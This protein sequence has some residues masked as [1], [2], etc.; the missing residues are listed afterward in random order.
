MENLAIELKNGPCMADEQE[1]TQRFKEGSF[2]TMRDKIEQF[3]SDDYAQVTA[4]V[5]LAT[6]EPSLADDG[7]QGALLKVASHDKQYDAFAARVMVVAA[8]D[9]RL[10]ARRQA[11]ADRDAGIEKVSAQPSPTSLGDTVLHQAL[12]EL[13]QRQREVALLHYYLDAS[14]D[15]IAEVMHLNASTVDS[16]IAAAQRVIVE[17]LQLGDTEE[18]A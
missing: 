4:A 7:V 9:V 12:E 8:G 1:V 10:L 2:P 15:D 16:H 11:I 17:H 18:D 5:A 6:D 3:I 13:P 14:K